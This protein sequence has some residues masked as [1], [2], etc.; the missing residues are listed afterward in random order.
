MQMQVSA[1]AVNGSRELFVGAADFQP[2][3][4]LLE[5]VI[6]GVDS[7]VTW[8]LSG[9]A[10]GT[11]YVEDGAGDVDVFAESTSHASPP[12]V[13]TFGDGTPDP[14]GSWIIHMPMRTSFESMGIAS[15]WPVEAYCTTGHSW[16]HITSPDNAINGSVMAADGTP[17][18]EDGGPAPF[19]ATGCKIVMTGAIID[20]VLM[21]FGIDVHFMSEMQLKPTGWEQVSE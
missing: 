1:V 11:L 14:A 12:T 8:M 4:M 19:V 18:T 21:G 7:K 20:R 17:C 15:S 16:G 6:P 2:D 5:D 3:T 13:Y 9:D 10:H